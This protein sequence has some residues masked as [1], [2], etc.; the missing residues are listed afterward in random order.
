VPQPS[1]PVWLSAGSNSSCF[2]ECLPFCASPSLPSLVCL[3]LVEFCGP[4]CSSPACPIPAKSDVIPAISGFNETSSKRR[5]RSPRLSEWEQCYHL[6]LVFLGELCKHSVDLVIEVVYLLLPLQ[7]EKVHL[8]QMRLLQLSQLVLMSH[9][10]L[11]H[12]SVLQLFPQHLHFP[13][14]SF[15]LHVLSSTLAVLLSRD[16]LF[17]G[18]GIGTSTRTACSRRYRFAMF[19]LWFAPRAF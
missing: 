6:F 14:K 7:V 11:L 10:N 9:P 12:F 16:G 1:S 18:W 5:G 2:S 8:C 17:S 13:F 4:T 3:L 19:S 15:S